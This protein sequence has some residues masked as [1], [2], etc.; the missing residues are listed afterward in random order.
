YTQSG[1]ATFTSSSG[2]VTFGAGMPT[3]SV[4]VDPTSE[5]TTES[6]ETVVVT[7][8]SGTGYNIGSTNVATGTII[9][10]DTDITISVS[11]AS[12][13]EDGAQN[14]VYTFTRNGVTSGA[15]TVNFSVGG[16]AT[17][18]TDYTQSGAAT[19]ASSSG[20][21]SFGA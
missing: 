11:P 14:L 8:T 21:V 10:D 13:N 18:A 16:T 7:L 12:V 6:D 15:L 5:L 4:T 17:F 19:F 2:T 1:A 20:S 3:A 9:N